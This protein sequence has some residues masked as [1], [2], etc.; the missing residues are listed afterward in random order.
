[1]FLC[2]EKFTFGDIFNEVMNISVMYPVGVL[3]TCYRTISIVTLTTSVT[4]QLTS[5][6]ETSGSVRSSS[7]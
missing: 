2:D 3:S 4:T 1:M 7:E 6:G 5:S